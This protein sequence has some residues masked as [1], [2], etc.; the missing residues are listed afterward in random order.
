MLHFHEPNNSTP[1]YDDSKERIDNQ[2]N[3]MFTGK[4]SSTEQ[5]MDIGAQKHC[6]SG[7]D[8]NILPRKECEYSPDLKSCFDSGFLC[9]SPI[10]KYSELNSNKMN[11]ID[12]CQQGNTSHVNDPAHKKQKRRDSLTIFQSMIED[13]D[14]DFENDD[15]QENSFNSEL[16]LP[17]V[18]AKSGKSS[19]FCKDPA[20]TV[21]IN[22]SDRANLG[23]TS[24][25][26][27]PAHKKQKR[28]DSL[29]IFQSMIEDGDLDFE[30]DDDQENSF[31]SELPLPKV[32]AKS[33]KSSTFCKDPAETVEINLSNRANL[34][35]SVGN[36]PHSQGGQLKNMY[37]SKS[38]LIP[39]III[40][41]CGNTIKC[42]ISFQESLR[43]SL[44]SHQLLT[45]WDNMMGLKM[46]HARTMI[47]SAKSRKKLL[48]LARKAFKKMLNTDTV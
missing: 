31:N 26:N 4:L 33:G 47:K 27:D 42:F 34:M 41:N 32:T 37:T 18:T 21:E 3:T 45:E 7:G 20:E 1:A 24:H 13:G 5:A 48:K 30:N 28:R 14:L 6:F 11:N 25:V 12:R 23:N 2:F 43:T 44:Q 39:P 16:P 15:D 38:L 9:G 22:L 40:G 35:I 10:I 19:T 36:G 29:T 8:E 17:K 46:C